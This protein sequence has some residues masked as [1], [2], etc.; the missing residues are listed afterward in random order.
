MSLLSVDVFDAVIALDWA[1]EDTVSA[2]FFNVVSVDVNCPLIP[3]IV[4]LKLA[5]I[6]FSVFVARSISPSIFWLVLSSWEFVFDR[7][8]F[9]LFKDWLVCS[10]FLFVVS[11]FDL[12][13]EIAWFD[14]KSIPAPSPWI[15]SNPF[16]STHKICPLVFDNESRVSLFGL[17]INEFTPLLIDSPFLSNFNEPPSL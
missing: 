6:S 4:A 16:V 9:V 13:S 8:E 1:V 10:R 7:S 14:L 5:D 11:I 3:S 2:Y 17:T 12:I 15:W